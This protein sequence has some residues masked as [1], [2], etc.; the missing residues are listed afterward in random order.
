MKRLRV[1][2]PIAAVLA[3]APVAAHAAVPPSTGG[4]YCVAPPGQSCTFVP[5]GGSVEGYISSTNASWTIIDLTQQA[6]YPDHPAYWQTASGSG[7]NI[8]SVSY[9]PFNTYRLT[10]SGGSTSIGFVIAGSIN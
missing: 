2:L 9:I 8:A 10:V 3:A 5:D 6:R 1:A 7:P 4:G